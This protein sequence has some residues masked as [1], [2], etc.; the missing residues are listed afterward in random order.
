VGD[1]NVSVTGVLTGPDSLALAE[2]L[3]QKGFAA[4]E[5]QFDPAKSMRCAQLPINH[6]TALR[7][8]ASY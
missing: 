1:Y 6:R 4:L 7:F 3:V 2:S 5:A 8:D